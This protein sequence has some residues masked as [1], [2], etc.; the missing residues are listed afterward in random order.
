MSFTKEHPPY[1][2]EVL[3]REPVSGKLT[4]FVSK[5]WSDWFE[6]TLIPDVEAAP[7]QLGAYSNGVTPL[8]DSLGLTVVATAPANGQYLVMSAVQILAAAGVASTL[9]VTVT[10]TK[11]TITQTETFATITNGTSA[12]HQG[13]A[14]P[15]LADG[16]TPISVNTTY[17]SNP[18][19]DMEY[20]LQVSVNQ[21]GA[22]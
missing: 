9:S 10:W 18:A 22:Q 3:A 20:D 4:A 16:N 21:V 5:L 6:Q 8:N 2:D 13:V 15:I 1:D 19:N 12:S 17:T 11:N 7:L 14:Y